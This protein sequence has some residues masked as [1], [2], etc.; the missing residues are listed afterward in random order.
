M[1][2]Y[3]GTPCLSN[4]GETRQHP[5]GPGDVRERERTPQTRASL[6]PPWALLVAWGRSDT[7]AE[8]QTAAGCTPTARKPTKPP[9]VSVDPDG[10][11][12]PSA[13]SRR[14]IVTRLST[15]VTRPPRKG[16]ATQAAW[17]KTRR[18]R[19]VHA[20]RPCR[21]LLGEAH[22]TITRTLS[23]VGLKPRQENR[24]C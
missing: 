10:T 17:P 8:R 7:P 22:R 20:D 23:G 11:S 5:G 24:I 2:C 21:R 9:E 4:L 16:S 12:A 3:M 1:V 14:P 13:L 6:G 18:G 15:A 19:G